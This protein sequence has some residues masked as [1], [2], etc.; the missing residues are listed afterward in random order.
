MVSRLW[1]TLLFLGLI[2]VP[3]SAWAH[4]PSKHKGKATQGEVLSVSGDGIELK[5][6]TGTK[7]Q[8]FY[9]GWLLSF[10]TALATA[11]VF[12]FTSLGQDSMQH[13]SGLSVRLLKGWHEGCQ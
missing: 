5:T 2:V 3:A 6:A 12:Q 8:K 4:N 9:A 13:G 10:G 11:T 1:A 7:T